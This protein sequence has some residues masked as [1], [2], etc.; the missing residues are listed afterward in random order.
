MTRIWIALLLGSG[1]IVGSG[2]ES[3]E[4]G[5][6]GGGGGTVDML[7]DGGTGT[8]SATCTGEVYDPCNDP[9]QCSSGRCQLFS[10]SGI[11]VCT[12]ACTPGDDTTCPMQNGQ[13]AQCNTKGIC[14]P[15][16]ANS[17]SR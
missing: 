8:A 2:T 16:G 3:G 17:C 14:K 15:P 9:S 6:G 5:G 7:V 13:A 12:Q 11:Q 10:Q 4:G 1:C